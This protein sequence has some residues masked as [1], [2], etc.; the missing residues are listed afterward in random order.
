MKKIIQIFC[1]L[2]ASSLPALAQTWN[3]VTTSTGL[4]TN[5]Y[6]SASDIILDANKNSYVVGQFDSQLIFG[7]VSLN[8]A[9]QVIF[10]AKFD[11]TGTCLWAKKADAY[12]AYSGVSI[13]L[14]YNQ[15]LI[16]TGLY[17]SSASFDTI[18]INSTGMSDVFI[19]KISSTGQWKWAKS[20]G[21]SSYDQGRQIDVDTNNNIYVTGT[22]VGTVVFDSLQVSGLGG[23]DV[24]VGKFTPSGKCLWVKNSAGSGNE[25]GTCLSVSEAGNLYVGGVYNGTPNIFGTAL[26]NIGQN[27]EYDFISKLDLNGNSIWNKQ[28]SCGAINNVYG[29]QSI[30]TDINDNLYITGNYAY[31]CLLD[32]FNFAI[33]SNAVRNSYIAKLNPSGDVVWAKKGNGPVNS[34]GSS[35]Y[36][37]VNRNCYVSGSYTDSLNYGD[38]SLI[39]LGSNGYLIKLDSLGHCLCLNNLSQTNPVITGNNNDLWMTGYFMNSTNFGTQIVTSSNHT[40]VFIVNATI[41]CFTITDIKTNKIVRDS[42][43]SISPN[44]FKDKVIVFANGTT[45]NIQV[46]N[47]LGSIIYTTNPENEITE[48]DLSNQS[49]GVYFVRIGSIT[50]KIIKQ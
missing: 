9:S 36:I 10:I 7:S 2:Y 28:L 45:Q 42:K 39:N 3:W 44:P 5:G 12:T 19:A 37:D 18:T 16:I 40:E 20:Y 48:I 32:T 34:G 25:K 50:K 1:F 41:D 43:I 31:S 26:N 24:F 15:D 14:D 11:S 8:S 46:F 21:G 17:Y 23:Y 22:S 30:S 49:S 27:D 38:C 13:T 33:A 35:I 4:T 6:N 29:L 47:T